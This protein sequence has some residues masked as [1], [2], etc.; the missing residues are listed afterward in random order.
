L[1]ARYRL[2]QLMGSHPDDLDV[3]SEASYASIDICSSICMGMIEFGSISGREPT[4]NTAL[5]L[6]RTAYLDADR[7]AAVV[8]GLH[9]LEQ[10]KREGSV[11]DSHRFRRTN[12]EG[13]LAVGG[14]F[15]MTVRVGRLAIAVLRTMSRQPLQSAP[16][17]NLSRES[18]SKFCWATSRH[19]SRVS[20]R[21][22]HQASQRTYL[23]LSPT[24]AA[25]H[26]FFWLACLSHAKRHQW[27]PHN[28]I[29]AEHSAQLV[30]QYR[31]AESLQ[32]HAVP[33]MAH[34]LCSPAIS[35]HAQRGPT[36][37]PIS[38]QYRSV[39]S[40]AEEKR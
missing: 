37:A 12:E 30:A 20:H 10:F 13:K 21:V 36:S 16:F 3:D 35:P 22:A 33:C 39:A 38:E 17:N 34:V 18:D 40:Q 25:T 29:Q 24:Q 14:K 19:A 4:E 6:T 8:R 23:A 2:V 31:P 15:R 9:P 5:Q 27:V 1:A 7:T 32:S 28:P 11:S 26:L